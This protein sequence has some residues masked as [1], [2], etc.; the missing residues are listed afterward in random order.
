M[1]KLET[2]CSTTRLPQAACSCKHCCEDRE[3]ERFM[4]NKNSQYWDYYPAWGE[5]WVAC[6]GAG[7]GGGRRVV[8]KADPLS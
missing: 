3:V 6:F 7:S 5:M 2:T 8:R 1:T 4:A